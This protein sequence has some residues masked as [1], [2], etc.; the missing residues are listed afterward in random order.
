MEYWFM[1][2]HLFA[3]VFALIGITSSQFL[4]GQDKPIREIV[5][6]K[7]APDSVYIGGTGWYN[8]LGTAES[9]ILAGEF[10]Y[11]TPGPDFIQTVVHPKPDVWKWEQA[12]GNIHPAQLISLLAL[13]TWKMLKDEKRHG[14]C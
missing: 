12:D 3:L 14:R 9:S 8:R 5:K 11:V 13:K 2:N 1:K 6:E 7:Y 10:S 4:Y